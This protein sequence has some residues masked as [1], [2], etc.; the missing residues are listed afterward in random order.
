MNKRRRIQ[1]VVIGNKMSKTVI[2]ETSRTF[3]HPLYQ[4]VVHSS[5]KLVAHDELGCN[6]GDE[7]LIVE[8]KPI[9]RTKRFV[10]EKILSKQTVDET[11]PVSEEEV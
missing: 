11:K 10:V 5:G 1:A 4:K 2:V 8:S 7:V 3:R 6:V 9:S